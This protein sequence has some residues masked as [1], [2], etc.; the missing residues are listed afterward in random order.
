MPKTDKRVDAYI[1]RSP[2]FARPILE[3]LRATW[4]KA[5]PDIEETIK[6]G[7]P[8]FQHNGLVG[9]MAAFKAHV[10]LGFWKAKLLKDPAGILGEGGSMSASRIRSLADLPKEKALIAIIREAVA[11][12]GDGGAKR[13]RKP[14]QV[15]AMPADFRNCLQANRKAQ[16]TFENFPPSQRREY[17]EWIIEA[18][19]AA[20]RERRIAQAVEWLAEGKPRHW[21]YMKKK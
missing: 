4:H 21:K 15:P 18:K 11:L 7:V 8:Y 1:R 20:T 2:E 5:C 9:G 13:E 6:W 3:R 10:G 17:L 12:N 16:A 19:Q 14:V